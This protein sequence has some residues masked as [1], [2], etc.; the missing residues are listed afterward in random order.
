MKKLMIA[1]I[2]SI[3]SFSFTPNQEKQKVHIIPQPESVTFQKGHFT[4]NGD[5]R[6]FL[7]AEFLKDLGSYVNEKMMNE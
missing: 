2:C 6:L 7:P 3:G 1:F 5:T 4:L